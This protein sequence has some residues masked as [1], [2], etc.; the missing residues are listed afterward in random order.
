MLSEFVGTLITASM[1][2]RDHAMEKTC[3]YGEGD[4]GSSKKT[5]KGKP[6][7]LNRKEVLTQR[8]KDKTAN[9]GQSMFPKYHK[10]A[11]KQRASSQKETPGERDVSA[12][13][14]GSCVSVKPNLHVS[15]CVKGAK[16]QGMYIMLRDEINL[17]HGQA[18]WTETNGSVT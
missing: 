5:N 17:H 7:S 6:L 13:R 15:R 8:L 2:I 16:T 18:A 12:I 4:S 11:T 14:R 10:K 9:N 1:C 3:L